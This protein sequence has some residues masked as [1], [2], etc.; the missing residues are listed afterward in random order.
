MDGVKIQEKLCK[1][2]GLARRSRER[3]AMLAEMG[4]ENQ[5]VVS[6]DDITGK[7]LPWHAVRKAR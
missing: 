6:V 1:S 3:Q 5:D 2:N 7:E 4:E